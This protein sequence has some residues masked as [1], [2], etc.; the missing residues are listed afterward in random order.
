MKNTKPLLIVA[1]LVILTA[2]LALAGSATWDLNP[3]SNDWSTA[4]NWTPDTVPNGPLDTATFDASNITDVSLTTNTEVNSIVFNPGASSFVTTV[5]GQGTSSSTLTISGAGVINNSGITQELLTGPAATGGVGLINLTGNAQMGNSMV[6]TN[7]G[8][9]TLLAEAITIFA[10]NASAGGA[11]F[12]N[13]GGLSSRRQQPGATFFEDSS[14]AAQGTFF[15][16]SGHKEGFGGGVAFFDNS[17]AGTG[18]FFLEGGTANQGGVGD[19]QFSPTSSADNAVFMINGTDVAGTAGGQVNFLGGSTAAN[20]TLIASGGTV[21]GGQINFDSNDSNTARIELFGNGTL[22]RNN[23]FGSVTIGSLEGDGIVLLGNSA[24]TIGS[25]SLNTT[26]SG[27]IQE[28]GSIVKTGNGSLTLS[29]ANAYTGGTTIA[30]GTLVVANTAG[31]A[32]GTGSVTVNAGTL[33]GSG[34]VSGPIIV[35]TGGGG[36]AFLAPAAGTTIQTRLTAQGSLTLNSDATFTYTFKANNKHA[37]TDMVIANGVTINGATFALIGTTQGRMKRGLVLSLI[38]NTS[39]NPITGTF[40]N[41]PDGAIVTVNG[42][43]LQANYEGGDGNDLT[44]TVVP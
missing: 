7:K 35:G 24:F 22:D 30:A 42:N 21:A 25:N 8:G 32:T 23:L 38:S 13:D 37:R 40:N 6:I 14:T 26:F 29:G 5:V 11:T 20:A 4:A 15:C 41:L 1:S 27:T 16:N 10:D 43:N 17:T 2:Q 18:T 31:S 44:L 12:I 33:G 3:T 9:S 28:N 19:V 39:A 36:G 34:I